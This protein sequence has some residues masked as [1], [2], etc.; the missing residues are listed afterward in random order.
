MQIFSKFHTKIL[1]MLIIIDFTLLRLLFQS[2]TC[3]CN[4]RR[5]DIP[6]GIKPDLN[7]WNISP[8]WVSLLYRV[9]S[10]CP[11]FVLNVYVLDLAFL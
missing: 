1:R 2:L 4:N 8:Q 10:F 7:N 6:C 3:P 11:F 5:K 9:F